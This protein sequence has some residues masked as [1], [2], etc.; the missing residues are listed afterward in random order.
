MAIY[1]T[2]TEELTSI[3]DA[4]RA[5]T[6]NNSS[7][8]Y[9]T[10]F[11]NAIN[12]I[13]TAVDA[14]FNWLGKNVELVDTLYNQSIALKD[15]S[16]D[17]STVTTSNTNIRTPEALTP[18]SL[19]AL[20]DYHQVIK[21]YTDY[22]YIGNPAQSALPIETYFV[23]VYAFGRKPLNP[24]DLAN[25]E[26]NYIAYGNAPSLITTLYYST[27]G[28]FEL[29]TNS[30]G[31]NFS[32]SSPSF[33]NRYSDTFGCTLYTPYIRVNSNTVYF[34]TNSINALDTE[35]TTFNI[36]IELYRS[37]QDS[38]QHW[39]NQEIMKLYQQVHTT[40]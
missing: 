10:G 37:E 24:S 8:V 40:T 29:T 14:P 26:F 13:T 27:A 4:I 17:A 3:A 36:K 30:Y 35:N 15:T 5:K 33:T 34:S 6:G 7:L 31:F 38:M 22:H 28:T 12:G 1:R 20:Y 21:I 9:P 19:S 23:G 32:F 2:N 16:F 25:N 39:L 11:V 18:L